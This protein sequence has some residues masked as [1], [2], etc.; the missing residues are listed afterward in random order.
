MKLNNLAVII[1]FF[2]VVSFLLSILKIVSLNFNDIL[3]YTLLL[4]G[5]TLVYSESIHQNG[6][7]VFLGSII[8]LLGVYFLISENFTL[9]IPEGLSIPIILIFAGSGLLILHITS[10]TR[11][12]FLLVS[13]TCLLTGLIIFILNS[14]IKFRSAV[15]SVMPVFNYLWPV[16]IILVILIFI[17]RKE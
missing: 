7:S 6:L 4:T 13:V 1:I 16:L 10:S 17:F 2:I 11:L 12:I 8:F 3:S 5:I 15:Y 9:N 14:R